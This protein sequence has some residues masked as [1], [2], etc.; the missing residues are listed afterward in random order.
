MCKHL[1]GMGVPTKSVQGMKKFMTELHGYMSDKKNK[2]DCTLMIRSPRKRDGS[3]ALSH[4]EHVTKT[5]LK[6]G[7]LDVTTMNGLDQGSGHHGRIPKAPGTNH[8]KFTAGNKGKLS[9][10][11]R[12]DVERG[13][14]KEGWKNNITSVNYV[15]CREP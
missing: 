9:S 13:A 7:K 10:S 14:K 5:S 8:W 1:P 2:W 6:A 12:T 3:Y 4:F 15:C 11:S